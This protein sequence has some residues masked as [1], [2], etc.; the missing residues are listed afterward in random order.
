MIN[1]VYNNNNKKKEIELSKDTCK[2]KLNL[3]N[4]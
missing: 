1:Q 3:K 2:I 4:Y